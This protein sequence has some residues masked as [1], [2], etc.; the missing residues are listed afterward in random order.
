MGGMDIG[1]VGNHNRRE[2][3]HVAE[4]WTHIDRSF[5]PTF[6]NLFR[7][8]KP[9]PR[10]SSILIFLE[11]QCSAIRAVVSASYLFTPFL[12][13]LAKYTGTVVRGRISDALTYLLKVHMCHRFLLLLLSCRLAQ[14]GLG[15]FFSSAALIVVIRSLSCEVP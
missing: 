6:D 5:S 13:R 9:N 3:S 14:H 12:Q 15:F 7:R 10:V 11:Y 2:L 1:D 4:A 8:R